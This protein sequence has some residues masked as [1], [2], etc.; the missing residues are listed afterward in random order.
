MSCNGRAPCITTRQRPLLLD[1]PLSIMRSGLPRR[2][3]RRQDPRES[4]TSALICA[5]ARVRRTR[6]IRTLAL[7]VVAL[8]PTL[9]GSHYACPFRGSRLGYVIHFIRFSESDG[10]RNAAAK[11]KPRPDF[12]RARKALSPWGGAWISIFSPSSGTLHEPDY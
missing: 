7:F 1:I 3:L 12:A 10:R 4:F 11:K 6:Y 8:S 2:E 5:V 9:T